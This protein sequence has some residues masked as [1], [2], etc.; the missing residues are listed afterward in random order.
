MADVEALLVQEQMLAE[1]A[2][3]W[4]DRFQKESD[5]KRKLQGEYQSQREA[6][7]KEVQQ[8]YAEIENARKE[9]QQEEARARSSIEEVADLR[10][11]TA[12]LQKQ[13]EQLRQRLHE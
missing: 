2:K 9:R 13:I 11:E 12:D 10:E 7:D 4:E 8:M 3:W 6:F 1:Q 5:S